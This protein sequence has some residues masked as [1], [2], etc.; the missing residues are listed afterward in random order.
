[1]NEKNA[2]YYMNLPYTKI[3]ILDSDGSWFAKIE[4]LPG[5]MTVGNN[6]EDALEMLND[7]L[8]AWLETAIKTGKEIPEPINEVE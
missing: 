5:C 7:A 1:M 2:K 4:E 6:K 8:Q 3:L